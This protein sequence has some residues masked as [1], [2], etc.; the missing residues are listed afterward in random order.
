MTIILFLTEEKIVSPAS[1]PEYAAVI[2][3]TARKQMVQRFM[4]A[5]RTNCLP[6]KGDHCQRKKK[7]AEPKKCSLPEMID[8][9]R[10]NEQPSTY[11][12]DIEKHAP[13]TREVILEAEL[14]LANGEL[15][16]LEGELQYK[17][18]RYTV[19]GLEE[20]V[21]RMETGLPK[22]SLQHRCKLCS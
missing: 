22:K 9:A 21:I 11:D 7:K 15:I 16:G 4:T 19:A 5:T 3:G 2:L 6:N 10:K 12:A 20:D 14:D 18:I 1:I 13:T 17:S 8:I